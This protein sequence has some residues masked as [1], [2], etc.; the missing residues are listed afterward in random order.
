MSTERDRSVYIL[1]RFAPGQ[2]GG[3][4]RH[5][6]ALR[7]HLPFLGWRIADDPTAA[8][9]IHVHA[10]ERSPI[11]RVDVYTNHG[12][13]PI[14][15]P[16]EP[17][18][19]EQNRAIFDN[20][21][22]AEQIVAV[23]RWTAAQWLPLV[24]EARHRVIPNGVDLDEW[25]NLPR[26]RWRTRLGIGDKVPLV[27]WPKTGVNRVLDPTPALELALRF[28]RALFVL[29][30]P[31]ASLP[32]LPS[33]ARAIGP[34]PF[35]VFRTLL[36]DCDVYLAT[37]LENHSIGV[38][39][40]MAC[41]KAVIGYAL[42]GTA[43]TIADGTDGLL[44]APGDLDGL[45][46][47][48]EEGLDRVRR[49][50]LGQAAS[51]KVADRYQ[52][53]RIVAD[54]VEVYAMAEEAA[55]ATRSPSRPRVT[56]VIPVYNKKEYVREAVLSAIGQRGAPRYEIVAVDDGSTD[57]S[58]E[59]LDDLAREHPQVRVIH[60]RNRGVAAARN[61]GIAAGTGEYVCCLDGD[62]RIAP[63]FLARTVAAL[64]AD[65]LLGIAY[66][67]MLAFG[68]DAAGRPWQNVVAASEYDFEKLKR[69]NFIPCCN[70]FRRRAWERAGGYRDINP[71]WE[72]Y[73]LWLRMGKL[74]WH[75]RRVPGALF[76]YR[77]VPNVGRDHASHGQEWRLRAIVNRL[78]RD[79]YPPLVSV[80]IP[81]YG[82]AHF[83]PDALA[84]VAR[85]TMPDW[86][87]VVVDDG[88]DPEEAARVREAIDHSGLAG[89]DIRLVVNRRNLGLAAARNAGIAAASG[90]WIV[91]LDADDVIEPSFIEET[92]RA[93]EM[94]PRRFAYTDSLLWWPD[95][96]ERDQVLTALEY[97]FDDL[98]RRVTWP[99]T[100]LYAREAWRKVG[101]YKAAMSLAGG[102]EDWEFAISL[103]EIGICGV[104]VPRPLFRYRQHSRD[105]MRY[106]AE[107]VKD[108]LRE[109]MRRLHAATYRGERPM[110]C[111][112]GSRAPAPTARAVPSSRD[113]DALTTEDGNVLVKYVG[114]AWGTRTWIAP[115]GRAYR[116]SAANPLR[117]MP[118]ED[119]AFFAS[120][121]E[122]V[123][124]RAERGSR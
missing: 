49:E 119:A 122:F 20:L 90:T 104:R 89:T 105:Q 23:S 39:E 42:G 59:I 69:G 114:D 70:L 65:P 76:H 53:S 107:A 91:P 82:Q 16:L 22:L 77:K 73:E 113:L 37:T 57:G 63:D 25:Q 121:P 92:L 34:Q 4:M 108:R 84:S 35:D 24:G 60:Q 51:Q 115:S 97:D 80:V 26:G 8:T 47:K 71:S 44:A 31:P 6:R 5:V 12:I 33:N 48:F 111:C 62:D 99:C 40:A 112:G 67:D 30:A 106:R 29:L 75:G 10:A 45:A 61:A 66:T 118:T 18:Q 38:L 98:L 21:K 7:E 110:G 52:W 100:I 117:A 27:I 72:D 102:W 93:T 78:H 2:S 56:V 74:G 79:L 1:P 85:Q 103:G 17:W 124:I 28:P 68:V 55:H 123:T 94:D 13:H 15:A 11:G 88:N 32:V 101:G 96:P 41:G 9:L 87:I 58:G 64:D 50:A 81:C 46:R 120:L 116:F 3:V 95:A 19:R 83:L 43:E 14:D 109:T 86:E 54:L 36:A